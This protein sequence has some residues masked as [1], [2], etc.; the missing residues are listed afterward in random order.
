MEAVNNVNREVARRRLSD[1]D[2]MQR[3]KD[4]LQDNLRDSLHQ[5]NFATLWSIDIEQR[6][7]D[8]TG[9]MIITDAGGGAVRWSHHDRHHTH[10]LMV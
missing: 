4:Y 1:Y 2:A 5:E 9:G 6:E 8:A 7:F 3:T 10:D